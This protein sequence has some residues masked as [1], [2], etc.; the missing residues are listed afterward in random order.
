MATMTLEDFTGQA[1]VVVFPAVYA[2]IGATIAKDLAVEVTGYVMHRERPGNGG[3]KAVE[4]RLESIAMLEPPLDL[5]LGPE[6]P[7]GRIVIGLRSAT[8]PQLRTLRSVLDRYPGPYVVQ[9]QVA[10]SR[11]P[12]TISALVAPSDRLASEIRAE[13]PNAEVTFDHSDNP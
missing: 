11:R 8:E 10:P 5:D 12:F 1:S 9:I 2:K 3:E 13:L 7:S 4:V 6:P